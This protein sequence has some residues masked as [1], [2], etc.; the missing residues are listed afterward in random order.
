MENSLIAIYEGE[1]SDV[2]GTE[3]GVYAIVDGSL[4][5]QKSYARIVPTNT[6]IGTSLASCICE[7]PGGV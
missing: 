2:C 3:G 1:D 5:T 4:T 7:R 6:L